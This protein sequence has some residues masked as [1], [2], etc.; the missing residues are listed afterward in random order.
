[1]STSAASYRLSVERSELLLATPEESRVVHSYGETVARSEAVPFHPAR[2][3]SGTDAHSRREVVRT[4]RRLKGFLV[5]F[6]S[7]EARVA[8][9]ENG[10]TVFYDLPA[11][12]IRRAGI[13]VRNQPFQMDEIETEDEHGCLI[14]GY[15][16]L[17]LAQPS[18]AY[19]ETLDFDDERK[20]KR[21]LIL[22]EFAKAQ[23]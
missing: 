5:E 15:R 12:Q 4:K 22:K 23:S 20:R 17:P 16:F 19:I 8:F 10:E 18:D 11:D 9:V 21:D 6:Q 7:D 1:M 14:V 2:K 3:P 13:K